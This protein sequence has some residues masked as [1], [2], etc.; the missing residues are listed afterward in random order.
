[1]LAVDCYEEA[2]ERMGGK[3]DAELWYNLGLMRKAT[4]Q[5]DLAID[6]MKLAL[7]CAGESNTEAHIQNAAEKL[8]QCWKSPPSVFQKALKDSLQPRIAASMEDEVK[9]TVMI[10]STLRG[11]NERK[12]VVA[13]KRAVHQERAD[14]A[15][16]IQTVRRGK[17][18]RQQ[19]DGKREESQHEGAAATRLQATERG[20][21][22]RRDVRK[23]RSDQ[24]PPNEV[25]LSL[26]ARKSA[27]TTEVSL[28]DIGASVDELPSQ[29]QV[30]LSAQEEAKLVR[31]QAKQRGNTGRTES[32]KRKAKKEAA[33]RVAEEEVRQDDSSKSL[34][35]IRLPVLGL[36]FTYVI[37]SIPGH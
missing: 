16:K 21:Q 14:A 17:T 1:M 18:G 31:L 3:E 36:Y 11:R 35:F 34:S 28:I 27:A 24:P 22:S 4:A 19:V 12:G 10:Q 13:E 15:V 8:L 37:V 33:Q 25:S 29:A 9:A 5:H 32:K 20:R 7:A 23:V 6:A 30:Q 26:V 2:I